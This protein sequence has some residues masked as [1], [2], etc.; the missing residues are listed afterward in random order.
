MALNDYLLEILTPSC[1]V[2]EGVELPFNELTTLVNMYMDETEESD[3]Q[4]ILDY[5]S[6]KQALRGCLAK[7]FIHF[8]FVT[9]IHDVLKDL[10]LELQSQ[11][12]DIHEENLEVEK[13]D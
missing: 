10:A 8:D 7:S 4:E 12:E 11:V 1:Y 2:G 3:I 13:N 6:V 5:G 9:D